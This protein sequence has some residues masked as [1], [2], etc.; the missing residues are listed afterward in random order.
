LKKETW[1][2]QKLVWGMIVG[3]FFLASIW[4]LWGARFPAMQDYPEHLFQAKVLSAYNDPA[5]D[6]S[7]YFE[8]HIKPAPQ[9]YEPDIFF[10]TISSR[11]I[12]FS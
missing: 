11:I 1:P 10:S 5:F 9:E 7:R 12:S 8:V 3:A 2:S 4:P 6:Y